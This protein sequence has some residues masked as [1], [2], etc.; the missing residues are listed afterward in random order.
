M[1]CSVFS[2]A[3]RN[4]NARPSVTQRL[5][6]SNKELEDLKFAIDLAAIVTIT[7]PAGEIVYANEKM[8]Q[9][10]Q[11]SREEL[12]GKSH[13]ELNSGFH[14]K[15]FIRDLWD[16]VLA[17]KVWQ[18][19]IRNKAK[20]GT[21]FWVDTTIV[22]FLR[23]DGRP[24]QFMS[25]RKDVTQRKMAEAAL[26][27]ERAKH[28]YVE[29]LTALGEMASGIAHEIRNPLSA[30]L[31]QVQLLKRRELADPSAGPVAR[32]ADRIE[33]T[34]K[35]IEKIINGLQM[36]SRG[37]DQ[38]P[39]EEIRV[40]RIFE[41]TLDFCKESLLKKNIELSVDT[42][43]LDLTIWCRSGQISQVLLNLVN[44]AKDAISLLEQK[45]IKL[46]AERRED[47]VVIFVMDSG[48]GI[49]IEHRNRLMKPF[50]TTKE[51]GKGTG[52][53]L[54]ISRRIMESHGGD[55][56]LDETSANT[57]FECRFPTPLVC[58][59][60]KTAANG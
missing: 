41:D 17:G 53:G 6:A 25:I 50:F 39:L 14:S 7:N 15:E 46:G 8:L 12:I 43:G 44:N 49:P 40:D 27:E 55:L 36:L 60:Q 24:Y 51:R 11:Y 21:F 37:A 4:Y 59:N 54:H 5:A 16:T 48:A 1:P 19:E 28:A 57:R 58:L 20:D 13:R 30:I 3:G 45:W 23:D 47:A 10:S 35:R 18:G 26:E 29:R 42:S 31:L 9:I 33:S 38:D 34:A 56:H 32:A 22:P 2:N 52:L